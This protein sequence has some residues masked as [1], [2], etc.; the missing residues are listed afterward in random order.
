MG[1][2]HHSSFRRNVR[3]LYPILVISALALLLLLCSG[4][5]PL[6]RW[7]A[8]VAVTND[9]EQFGS[10][11]GDRLGG[12]VI[13]WSTFP[14][15]VRVQRVDAA[16]RLLWGASGVEVCSGSAYAHYPAQA[17][18]DGHGG[19]IVVWEDTRNVNRDIYAQRVDQGGNVMWASGGV[20]VCVAAGD[21]MNPLASPGNALE[22][23]I[24]W[25]DRRS[26][27]EDIYAQKLDF[28]GNPVCAADGIPVCAAPG[29]QVSPATVPDG[30]GGAYFA[31][32]DE[33]SAPGGFDIYAQRMDLHGSL[34][35][36][37]NGVL[38]CGAPGSQGS[39]AA[40]TDGVAGAVLTWEDERS[41]DRDLYAQRLDKTG[42]ALWAV[43]GVPVCSAPGGQFSPAISTG[44]SGGAVVT[45]CDSRAGIENYDVYAQK[46]DGQGNRSW[47]SAGLPVCTA[48]GDQYSPAIASDRQGGAIIAWSDTR[49][50]TVVPGQPAYFN[51]DVHVTKINSSGAAVW[52][53]AIALGSYCQYLGGVAADGS[54]G[55]FTGWYTDTDIHPMYTMNDISV[56]RVTDWDLKAADRKSLL[57]E[58]NRR[59]VEYNKKIKKAAGGVEVR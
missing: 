39:V 47:P 34:Q 7:T 22:S 50:T 20:P 8:D 1:G 51:F 35:W 33:R 57:D 43:G 19:A 53:Q 37:A 29:R 24:C 56:T 16:G 17:V 28:Y 11:V 5:I 41:G 48:V 27:Q 2:F 40:C 12:A 4:C 25:I 21:Q 14:G 58:Y 36:A 52:G 30:G 38:V 18:E 46:L 54:G 6:V 55:A 3:N 45:W 32:A 44:G 59:V 42:S 26:G 23:V 10:I 9:S 15:S 49:F 13:A 31:W